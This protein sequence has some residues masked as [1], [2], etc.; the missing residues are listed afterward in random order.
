[1]KTR[2]LLFVVSLCCACLWGSA[3]ATVKVTNIYLQKSS[4]FTE[5]TLVCDGVTEFTHQIVEAAANKPYRIVVDVKNAVPG[6]PQIT[7]KNLPSTSIKQIRTSQFSTDPEKVVRIVF[8]VAGA[9]TYKVKGG[10][11]TFTLQI[12]TPSDKDFP[13]WSA[14]TGASAPTLATTKTEPSTK[15]EVASKPQE[16]KKTESPAKVQTVASKPEATKKMET[17]AK[18]QTVASKPEATKK[19]EAPA[20]AQTVASKPEA[21][22]KMETPAKAQ[23]VASKPEAIKKVEAPAKTEVASKPEATKKA[24]APAKTEVASKPEATKKAETP[25]KIEVASQPEATKKVEAPAKTEVASKPEATKKV[26]TPAKT[27]A[28]ASK[29]EATK[30]GE[31]PTKIEA[32]SKPEATKKVETPAKA[33]TVAIT[34]TLKAMPAHPDNSATPP[35]TTGSEAEKNDLQ[36]TAK[37]ID[38]S[39]LL[40]KVNKSPATAKTEEKAQPSD[41]AKGSAT[42]DKSSVAQTKATPSPTPK[43]IQSAKLETKP[44]AVEPTV[45]DK[46]AANSDK[47]AKP[48]GKP[49]STP[50]SSTETTAAKRADSVTM[51]QLK[52]T[53]SAPATEPVDMAKPPKSQKT[54]LPETK[55]VKTPKYTE[56][57]EAGNALT[58][59]I[60]TAYKVTT[61]V[62]KPESGKDSTAA[63]TTMTRSESVRMRYLAGKETGITPAEATAD[64]VATADAAMSQTPPTEIEKIRTK[65]KRG[66]RFVQNDQDEEQ[67]TA[68]E[69]DQPQEADQHSGTIGAYNEFLPERE[70]VVYQTS[71]RPDPFMPLIEDAISNAKGGEL[72]DVETL[73]LVGILQ[74]KKVSRALFEDYNNYSYIL[75]TGD[76]V[77]NGFVLSIE[78]TRVLFQ[79]RQYG[80]NRQVAIDLEN[81]K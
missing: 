47:A 25:T 61:T 56:S 9:L 50:T 1:M 28:V 58:G 23:T 54:A 30:K 43:V 42:S 2:L 71:G 37:P 32:V 76:R 29:S 59:K 52:P 17:P 48:S 36:L 46:T 39:K 13:K 74:D 53:Q 16:T 81:E 19:V 18:A 12:N 80:W 6:L 7:F 55:V 34:Q 75:R 24:E 14:V 22:K 27:Q 3:T 40:T 41:L 69:T 26:E 72:P 63:G 51:P 5:V 15:I 60:A 70:I 10:G 73:R 45:V 65:Y 11:N 62:S 68:S 38:E 49:T 78:E 35:R 66:I 20:K 67:Q 77:K 33:Q 79:I 21:T 31:T 57:P 4:Q 44:T 8:D 64:S